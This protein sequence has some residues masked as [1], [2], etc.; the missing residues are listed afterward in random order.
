M[1]FEFSAVV[2]NP[3]AALPSG[4]AFAAP[5]ANAAATAATDVIA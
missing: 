2:F 3:A 1:R 4:V 5:K